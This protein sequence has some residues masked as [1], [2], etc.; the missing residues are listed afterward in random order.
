MGHTLERSTTE[1]VI[2]VLR[3]GQAPKIDAINR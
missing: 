3:G 1:K 2:S